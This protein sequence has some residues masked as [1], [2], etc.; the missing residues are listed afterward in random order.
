MR[1]S[2]KPFQRRRA[3]G[4]TLLLMAGTACSHVETNTARPAP[5]IVA[6]DREP[7]PPPPP[8]PPP[9]G[10]QSPARAGLEMEALRL[11][12]CGE[13]GMVCQV[14]SDGGQLCRCRTSWERGEKATGS[15][16]PHE[17]PL[18]IGN[19]PAASELAPVSR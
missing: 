11:R 4:L 6:A 19:V 18:Y 10:S 7:L 3:G 12:S 15:R 16:A 8:V 13:N 17:S 2:L 5:P 9:A 14:G 1:A